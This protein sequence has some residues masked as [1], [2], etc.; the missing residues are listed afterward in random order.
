MASIPS[1]RI[2]VWGGN[3][4]EQERLL[5]FLLFI[6][7]Y[8]FLFSDN[9]LPSS[10]PPPLNPHNRQVD[11]C[12][13]GEEEVLIVGVEVEVEVEAEVEA[14]YVGG[15]LDTNGKLKSICLS[16]SI[17]AEDSTAENQS[18]AIIS[19]FTESA[20]LLADWIKTTKEMYPDR[21]DL[22]NFIPKPSSMCVSK[23]LNGMIST[24]TCNTARLT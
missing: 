24:D 4:D 5:P 11:D 9:L 3:D 8:D 13:V 21:D 17:I 16:G 7:I 23:L 2:A 14:E 20:Q 1:E 10:I 18:R 22:V 6:F 12:V 15:I 19:S